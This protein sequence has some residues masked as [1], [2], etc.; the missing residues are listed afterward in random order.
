MKAYN[1]RMDKEM[2]EGGKPVIKYY[3]GVSMNAIWAVPSLGLILP[4][5]GNLSKERWKIDFYLRCQ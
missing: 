4:P 5:E 1:E 2:L 3:D